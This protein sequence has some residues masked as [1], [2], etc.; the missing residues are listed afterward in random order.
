MP[1]NNLVWFS[2]YIE[3]FSSFG[4]AVL[5]MLVVLGMLIFIHE[6]GH[7]L[8]AKKLG[9]GVTTFSL[10]FGKRIWGF[11][12]GE[13]DYCLSILPLGGYVKLMGEEP[14]SSHEELDEP[15]V[16]EEPERSFYLRPV[17]QR[18]AVIFAGPLFNILLA[19]ILSWLLFIVGQ[20]VPGTW[21][22]EVFLDTPANSAGLQAGD[23]IV[24]VDD[25]PTL[26]WTKLVEI[27]RAN[28][29]KRLV[30][31][32]ERK[33]RTSLLPIIPASRGPSGKEFGFGRIGIRRS[34][35]AYKVRYGPIDSIWQ[36]AHQTYSIIRLT[37][38]TLYSMLKRPET[39]DIGGPIRIAGIA[40]EQAKRGLSYIIGLSILLSLNLAILNLLPIPILDGGH[41]MF[42]SIEALRG[43]PLSTRFRE[44]SAQVGMV[45]LIGVMLVATYKD[46]MYYFFKWTR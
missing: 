36:S 7:F 3:W 6:L 42:L 21:V 16:L 11:R 34:P 2:P 29:G 10:G 9:I 27:I 31:R 41:L 40:G 19:L 44:I 20:P 8:V 43:K 30:L 33:G 12:K 17:Y 24:A 13:T 14:G 22:G 23:H 1:V 5:G 39:A 37:V 46:T 25:K 38:V 28:P 4:Y 26:Q 45:I 35:R 32:V 18:M 15:A